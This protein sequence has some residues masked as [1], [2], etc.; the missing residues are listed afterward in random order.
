VRLVVVIGFFLIS[1]HSQIE[2]FYSAEVT[3]IGENAKPLLAAPMELI[4]EGSGA[5]RMKW[6]QG[7]PKII[8][9][10]QKVTW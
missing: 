1:I 3:R 4:V 10:S 5:G 8:R 7:G 6:F 2:S 9:Q